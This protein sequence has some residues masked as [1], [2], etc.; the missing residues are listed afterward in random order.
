M[1]TFLL[2]FYLFL[3]TLLFFYPA[4]V[5]S[6]LRYVYICRFHI[7]S[8]VDD[9]YH[10]YQSL[11]GICCQVRSQ[12]AGCKQPAIIAL[13]RFATCRPSH[14]NCVNGV[15]EPTGDVLH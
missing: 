1:Y 5:K 6:V 2:F 14:R 13:G 4:D 12:L 10:G 11:A 7:S 3:K 8:I 15:P 9:K